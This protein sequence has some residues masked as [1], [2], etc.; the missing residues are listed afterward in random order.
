MINTFFEIKCDFC[1]HTILRMRVFGKLDHDMGNS[2]ISKYIEWNYSI[3]GGD[4]GFLYGSLCCNNP[5]CI[6]KM[7]NQVKEHRFGGIFLNSENYIESEYG[8]LKLGERNARAD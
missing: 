8:K 4:H 6:E 1:P 2:E 3:F 5:L 7:K